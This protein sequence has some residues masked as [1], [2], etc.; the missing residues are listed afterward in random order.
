LHSTPA[1]ALFGESRRDFSHGCVRVSDPMG[2]AQYVLRDSPEWTREMISA[3]MN[4]ER[5]LIVNLKNHIRV[6][7]VYGTAMATEQGNILFF[8]DIYGHDERLEQALDARQTHRTA[9]P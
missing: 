6:F 9:A 8:D 2:L 7:I 3:A 5:P 1:Q 4:G